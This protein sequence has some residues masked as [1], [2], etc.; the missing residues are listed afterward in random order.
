MAGLRGAGP[1]EASETLLSKA[2]TARVGHKAGCRE[3]KCSLRE[4]GN[5]LMGSG[6]Q[7]AQGG[8]EAAEIREGDG[9]LVGWGELR[10]GLG[11][12]IMELLHKGALGRNHL[13][14]LAFLQTPGPSL[15]ISLFTSDSCP[16]QTLLSLPKPPVLI[17]GGSHWKSHSPATEASASRAAQKG[18]HV[19]APSL[20]IPGAPISLADLFPHPP[21]EAAWNMEDVILGAGHPSTSVSPGEEQGAY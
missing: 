3:T 5:A 1:R 19:Q 6:V 2:R 12:R 14:T 20:S 21:P 15:T 10:K 17:P 8:A 4:E 11:W 13:R 9:L 18:L 16:G 7:G